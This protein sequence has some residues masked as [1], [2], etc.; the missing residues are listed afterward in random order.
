VREPRPRR[1]EGRL[2]LEHLGRRFS[3]TEPHRCDRV[4]GSELALGF[5]LQI[6]A[7]QR[8]LCVSP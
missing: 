3:E 4:V 5:K 1:N 2:E 8:L 6:E 7:A